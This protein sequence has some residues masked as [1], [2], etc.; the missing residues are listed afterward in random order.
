MAEALGNINITASNRD[1]MSPAFISRGIEQTYINPKLIWQ[2][3]LT[4]YVGSVEQSFKK[5]AYL[6]NA[7]SERITPET[8][9]ARRSPVLHSPGGVIPKIGK[10]KFTYTTDATVPYALGI[11]FDESMRKT[12]RGQMA[13]ETMKA[14]MRTFA[15]SWAQHLNSE[16]LAQTYGSTFFTEDGSA[17]LATY[18]DHSDG[19]SYDS[20]KSYLCGSLD[21]GWLWNT[22]DADYLTDLLNLQT[23]G[24]VQADT[25]GFE[26]SFDSL[27]MHITV[28]E[29]LILWG[30]NN[31]KRWELIPIGPG[32]K[33]ISNLQGFKIYA[34]SNSD[35]FSSTYWDHVLFWD[36]NVKPSTS[37][38]WTGTVENYTRWGP[39][40]KLMM[41]MQ[42]YGVDQGNSIAYD[43]RGEY[44]TFINPTAEFF[45]GAMEVY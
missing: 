8:S 9:S 41:G 37:V 23:V 11:E 20:T 3:L 22:E 24:Q 38:Y 36:S 6:I 32:R 40:A 1:Y 5:P 18:M 28:L 16:V 33:G 44:K 43:A 19:F 4:T 10:D 13:T 35:G 30:Q 27:A 12:P 42:D 15:A 29:D 21:S 39:N 26:A 34:I 14:S 31:N 7:S 2:D 45:Y 17:T 25:C